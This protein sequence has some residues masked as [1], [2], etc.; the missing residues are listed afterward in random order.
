MS[1]PQE[2]TEEDKCLLDMEVEELE[3]KVG[4]MPAKKNDERQPRS[5][6]RSPPKDSLPPPPTNNNNNK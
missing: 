4:D 6:L 1:K 5:R 2:P 3:N